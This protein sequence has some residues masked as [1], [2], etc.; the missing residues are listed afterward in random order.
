MHEWLANII[1]L[2]VRG[3]QG[4]LG[5]IALRTTRSFLTDFVAGLR[6]RPFHL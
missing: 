1:I 2:I 4:L 3:K 5:S 6:S